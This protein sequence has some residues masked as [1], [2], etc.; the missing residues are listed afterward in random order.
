MNI[1]ETDDWLMALPV[2]WRAEQEEDSIIISDEDGVGC[3]EISALYKDQG[4][5]DFSAQEIKEL[6]DHSDITAS[7]QASLGDFSGWYGQG[8]EDD[9]AIRQWAVASANVLLFI[10]Y[11]CDDEHRGLDD[12]AVDELLSTL[13][14]KRG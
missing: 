7:E 6:L 8:Q 9:V 2:E 5:G 4:T 1:V 10:T 13:L 11:S 3:I 12:A 14:L